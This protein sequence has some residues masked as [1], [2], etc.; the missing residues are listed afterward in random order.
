MLEEAANELL[1]GEGAVLELVSGGI[2][3]RERD[4]ASLQLAEAVVTEGHAKDVRG[5]IFEGL[6]AGA[7]R[8]GMDD[9]LL[10]P[11]IG[12]AHV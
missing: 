3:V 5:E 2:F 9:P 11:E 7:D 12:R 1:G 10:F 4:L 8:F 6:L